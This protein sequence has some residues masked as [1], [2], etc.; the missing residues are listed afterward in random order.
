MALLTPA[1]RK[2]M[3]TS[4]GWVALSSLLEVRESSLVGLATATQSLASGRANTTR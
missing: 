1:F 3:S 4:S 2:E